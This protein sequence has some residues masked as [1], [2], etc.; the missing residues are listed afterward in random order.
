MHSHSTNA[1]HYHQVH[2]CQVEVKKDKPSHI[3]EIKQHLT[4]PLYGLFDIINE[5]LKSYKPV[6]KNL[7]YR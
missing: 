6:Y 5:L 1:I 4:L 2:N 3:L 7:K